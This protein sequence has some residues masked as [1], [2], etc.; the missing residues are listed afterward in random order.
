MKQSAAILALC[1]T[2]ALGACAFNVAPENE[3]AASSSSSVSSESVIEDVSY[4]GII[5]ELG[6]SIYMQ[7]THK[8]VLENGQFLILESTSLDLNNY[9]ERSVRV[10]GDV[11]PTVEEGG[12][13]MRVETVSAMEQSSESSM[14]SNDSESSAQ[15]TEATSLSSRAAT[16]IASSRA[17][18]SS[19]ASSREAASVAAASS[20]SQDASNAKVQA[21]AKANIAAANWTEKFCS[22][23]TAFCIPVHKNWWFKSFGATSTYLEHMEVGPQEL[24]NLGDGPVSINVV[25]G[26]INGTGKSDGQVVTEGSDSVGYRA[27]SNDRHIEVRAPSVLA[28]AVRY[29]TQNIAAA[30]V[31]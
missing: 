17:A 7:G 6:V 5:R 18:A 10:T 29:I 16:S 3:G 14:S 30:P 22:R 28:E 31:Q 9:L 19:I 11:R 27:W 23:Q 4:T 24:E 20:V 12:M 25:S 26:S 1:S 15:S 8:L 13:I 2:V 21:M